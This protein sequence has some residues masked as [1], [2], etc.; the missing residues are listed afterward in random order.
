MS[1]V[2]VIGAGASLGQ[3]KALRPSREKEYPPL[4]Y[5]FFDRVNAIAG[6]HRPIQESLILLQ[7]RL[8][9]TSLFLDPFQISP[10]SLEQFFA[11]VYYEVAASR[12]NESFSI[13]VS[14]LRLYNRT[15]RATTE[16]IGKNRRLGP[17]DRILR[18]EI[19]RSSSPLTAI[20]FNQDLVLEN[21]IL[22]LPRT[23]GQWCL[24]SL[25]GDPPFK[26][27]N[28]GVTEVFPGHRSNCP[29]NP[30]VTVLKL[31]GSLN[32]VVRTRNQDPAVSTLFPRRDPTIM[33]TRRRF[34]KDSVH[35]HM[36][37]GRGRKR[38]YLWPIIVPPIYEK[39]RITG[40][41]ALLTMW[42]RARDAISTAERVVLV[43]YSLPEAD[44]GAVQ[45]M[46]RA[47]L[48]NNHLN[49]VDCVNPDA[50]IASKLK[51]RL[52]CKVVRL[53]H[54]MDSYLETS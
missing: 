18:K 23:K 17:I 43:G 38:W 36:G 52:G 30:P 9:S 50:G 47:F 2:L 13:F 14:L 49:V 24:K 41:P 28:P 19:S 15:L 11:D 1:T 29:H 53:Y 40:M 20:T 5:T 44:V 27:L 10:F 8:S 31:H 54:D 37:A 21:V 3:V 42:E 45:M 22:R 4:D 26:E 16:W 34:P 12:S 51:E 32:W 35:L 48:T 7:R 6:D 39:S 46:R 25:Y 33:L